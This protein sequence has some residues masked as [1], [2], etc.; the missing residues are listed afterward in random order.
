MDKTTH[1]GIS[2]IDLTS[3]INTRSLTAAEYGS[4]MNSY[5]IPSIANTCS[6]FQ[7]LTATR[8]VM[9]ASDIA[10]ELDLPRTSVFRILKTLEEEGMVRGVG[11][12]YVM[13]HRLINL[14]LQVVSQIPERDLCV[15]VLHEL[16]QETEESCHFAIL[17]GSNSLLIEVC[18]SP[19]ALRVASR[20]GTLADMH[21][22][23]SGKC[24]LAYATEEA[25]EDLLNRIKFTKRTER[26]HTSK[27][28]LI[29]E[30]DEIRRRGYAIDNVEYH[31]H[32]RCLGVPVF[33]AMGQVAGVIGVT[34]ARSRF[35]KSRIPELAKQAIA[36]AK[37][38]STQL[39]HS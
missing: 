22:S 5:R 26:T 33:N 37:Q 4:S 24:M 3:A 35:P 32:V 30:F 6:I 23:A 36:A 13:G 11:K 27:E 28:S 8:K 16:T 19:H 1:H 38:L 34:A 10:K 14:G 17:S 25:R 21:C 20:P 12:G 18:D 29:K 31:D 9:S 2:S 15:P 7:L 39:G